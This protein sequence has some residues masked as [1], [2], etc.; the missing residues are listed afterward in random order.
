MVARWI[1]HIC[2]VDNFGTR[3]TCTQATSISGSVHS[4]ASRH[5]G[6]VADASYY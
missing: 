4:S 6:L 1:W 2:T 5:A 3:A